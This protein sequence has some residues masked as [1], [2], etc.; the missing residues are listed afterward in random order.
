MPT[1]YQHLSNMTTPQ[2]DRLYRKVYYRMPQD[3]AM[4]GISWNHARDC[5]PGIYRVLMA[6]QEELKTRN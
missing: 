3:G 4:F 5:H 6:I 2:L 1:L